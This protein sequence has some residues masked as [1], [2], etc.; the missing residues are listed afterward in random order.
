[1]STAH[2]GP[3]LYSNPGVP[4]DGIPL[5]LADVV[6]RTRSGLVVGGGRPYIGPQTAGTGAGWVLTEVAVGAGN[7][8]AVTQNSLGQLT[9]TTD[10]ADEDQESL[11]FVNRSFRYST[12]RRLAC[13]ARLKVS[14]DITTDAFF[15]LAALDT[16]LVVASAA[17]VTD[18]IFFLKADTATDWT[19]H[20][21]AA[22]TSTT[23]TTG[24]TIADDTFMIIGFTVIGGAIRWYAKNDSADGLENGPNYLGS[25][26]AIANTNAPGATTDLFLSLVAG[27]EGTTARVVTV[28]WAFCTQWD[29]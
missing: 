24:L 5:D 18:G 9:L 27:V 22:S 21:R 29:V 17:G 3:L 13:F 25:G 14:D 4:L 23:A 16:T 7:T 8:G 10:N 19:V 26:T 28:D 20:V 1:M 12:T 2:R 6:N 11:Q 15:G